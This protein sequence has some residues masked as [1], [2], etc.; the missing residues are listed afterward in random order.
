[1]MFIFAGTIASFIDYDWKLIERLIDF[2]ELAVDDHQGKHAA[3]AFMKSASSRGGLD[4]ICELHFPISTILTL[5]G[6]PHSCNSP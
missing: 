5:C 1:M 4:K 6:S 2:K 3:K